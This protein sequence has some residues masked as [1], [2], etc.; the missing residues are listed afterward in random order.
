MFKLYI[1]H[2]IQVWVVGTSSIPSIFSVSTVLLTLFYSTRTGLV[3]LSLQASGWSS[4]WLS[5]LQVEGVGLYFRQQLLQSRHRGT[6]ELAYVGFVRLTDMLCRYVC[7]CVHVQGKG[8]KRN[9]VS[10][11]GFPHRQHLSVSL[12]WYGTLDNI[13]TGVLLR[14][15]DPLEGQLEHE[16][17]PRLIMNWESIVAH[18]IECIKKLKLYHI[19]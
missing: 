13:K 3:L 7:V 16:E 17:N 11:C 14:F 2:V 15:S 8:L 18:V 10:D 5:V 6:F 12:F 9:M 1:Y 19:I 4:L